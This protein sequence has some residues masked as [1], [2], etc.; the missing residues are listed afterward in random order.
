M[1]KKKKK[2]KKDEQSLRIIADF[3]SETIQSIR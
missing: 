1:I 3:L 2:K